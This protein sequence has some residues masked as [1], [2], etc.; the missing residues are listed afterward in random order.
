MSQYPFPSMFVCV[1]GVCGDLTGSAV[2][3]RGP[4]EAKAFLKDT[5]I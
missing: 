2:Y 3:K 1:S 5:L 4:L